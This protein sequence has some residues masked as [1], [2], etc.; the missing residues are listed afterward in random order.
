MSDPQVDYGPMINARSAATFREHWEAGRTE[1]ATLLSGGDQWTE[2]NRDDRVKGNVSHGA[3]MQPCV[4]DGV[5]PGMELFRN[6]VPGPTVNLCTFAELDQALTWIDSVPHVPSVSLHTR[7]HA[8]IGKFLQE[9]RADLAC[10]NLTTE[11]PG[12]RLPY[13]GQGTHPG[14]H[15]TLTGFTRWQTSNQQDLE[16]LPST[17]MAPG[18]PIQTDWDSL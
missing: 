15:L 8:W 17:E 16:A 10:V 9:S 7:D 4:W 11:P 13:T 2:A 1:G 12:A 5:T 14:R 6:Q 3:Y 18:S